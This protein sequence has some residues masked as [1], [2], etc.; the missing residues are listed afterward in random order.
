MTIASE[1]TAGATPAA[2]VDVAACAAREWD[3]IVIGAGPAGATAAALLATAGRSTLLLDRVAP[4]RRKVCGCCLSPRGVAAL[5][6]HGLA[7]ALD[8]ARPLHTLRLRAGDDECT[9][10]A[11]GFVAIG[12]DALDARLARCAGEAGA[13]LLWPASAMAR[14]DGAVLVRGGDTEALLR[15]AVVVVAD[16]LSGASLA[17]EPKAAWRVRPRSRMGAGAALREAP[18]ALREGEIVMLWDR[19]G[20]LGLVRLPDGTINAA[21]A[22]DP[23]AVREAG[24]PGALAGEVIERAGGDGREARAARWTGTALLS[25]SRAS[26]TVGRALLAGDAAGYAEP[27]TGEGMT[28]AIRGGALAAREAL[29]RLEGKGAAHSRS[30]AGSRALALER[31]RCAVASRALRSAM[32]TRGAVRAANASERAGR[33]MAACLGAGD[34]AALRRR[35]AA[36]AVGAAGSGGVTIG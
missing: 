26:A 34:S 8:G 30:I 2:T 12:R 35:A 19:R 33:C 6:E 14:A 27:F 9:L 13:A 4:P 21:A 36:G 32:L 22:W 5:R 28:W 25:R 15:A 18:L 16:G 11:R 20:Y 1:A 31:A 17:G 23:G 10:P 7:S 3:A 24:G 29:G